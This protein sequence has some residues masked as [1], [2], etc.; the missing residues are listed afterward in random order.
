[1]SHENNNYSCTV[2]HMSKY[3]I[4][5]VIIINDADKKGNYMLTLIQLLDIFF[6]Y[7]KKIFS[8]IAMCICDSCIAYYVHKW[9]IILYI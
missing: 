7:F 9:A 8:L 6:M 1:M 2:N 5:Q 3:I 4:I